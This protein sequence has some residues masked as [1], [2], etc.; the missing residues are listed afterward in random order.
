MVP[1][2]PM[3]ALTTAWVRPV[4]SADTHNSGSATS[5]MIIC[6]SHGRL[7]AKS[8]SRSSS[9]SARIS[10]R[11]PL[12]ASRVATAAPMPEAAPVIRITAWSNSD[13]AL[14]LAAATGK[15]QPV[16]AAEIDVERD[17]GDRDQADDQIVA[18][19]P[20]QLGHVL[21]VH[22]VNAGQRGR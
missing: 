18:I 2:A 16:A 21:E 5:P 9:W 17:A 4:R 12:P 8:R 3:P 14:P 22:P 6:R 10:L 11:A 19:L 20:L 1:P 13:M 15:S 7:K